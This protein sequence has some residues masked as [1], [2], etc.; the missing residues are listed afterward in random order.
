MRKLELRQGKYLPEVTQLVSNTGKA[1]TRGS[2]RGAV[3]T[4]CK[5]ALALGVNQVQGLHMGGASPHP[6]PSPV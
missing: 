2:K 6:R 1:R 5:H 3:D 4:K